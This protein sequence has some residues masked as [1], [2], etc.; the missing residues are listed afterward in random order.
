MKQVHKTAA[1]SAAKFVDRIIDAVLSP[2][3]DTWA[4]VLE[5]GAM[6]CIFT[7]GLLDSLHENY[8]EQFD[9]VVGV[10][11]GAACAASFAA[12]QRGRMQNIFINYLTDNRF[13]DYSR[14]FDS[15][16]S[17]LDLGYAIRDISTIHVPLDIEALAASSMKVY[18][19]LT[20]IE[21]CT[22]E[23]V[24]LNE[25]NAMQALIASCNIPFLSRTTI[26]FN[27]KEYIDGGLLDPIPVQKAIDLGANKIVVVLT[28]PEGFREPPKTL[29]KALLNKVFGSSEKVKS[30]LLHEHTI[31]NNC[32]V[33]VELF[34]SEDVELIV[35]TPPQD[36]KV[37]L[38]TRNKNSLLQGY[39]DGFI[40][41]NELSKK[42]QSYNDFDSKS[43]EK[44]FF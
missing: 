24:E 1:K 29:M 11:G 13:L 2:K 17:I 6:R 22:A 40:A 26:T 42:L 36:F 19:G 12:N 38:L 34:E 44:M 10:S 35:V 15:N 27:G 4:L 18:A 20:N 9:Y 41:G 25:E 21:D 33:F 43:G 7:A 14:A 8:V 30:L 23:Y 32:K 37:D 3:T 28:R 31:Y 5:G 39:A 16:K